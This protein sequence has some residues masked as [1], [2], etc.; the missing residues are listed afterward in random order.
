MLFNMCIFWQHNFIITHKDSLVGFM[1]FNATFSNSI[2]ISWRYVLLVEETGVFVE[3]HRPVEVTDKLYHILLYRVHLAMNGVRTRNIS[4]DR[5][6]LHRLL[7]IQLPCDH[8][9]GL[10]I[11]NETYIDILFFIIFI[12]NINK[13]T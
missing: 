4:S 13:Q 5:H 11:R 9:H 6:G 8:D 7:K 1:I 2:A 3:N 10:R 12:N